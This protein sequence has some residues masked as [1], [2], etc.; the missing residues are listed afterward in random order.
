MVQVLDQM[1]PSMSHESDGLIFQ[2]WQDPYKPGTC[3][4]L[5]KWKFASHNSVDFLLK[6]LFLPFERVCHMGGVACA[7]LIAAPAQWG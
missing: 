5:L 1:I 3:D 4:E 7:C 2:S 6:V